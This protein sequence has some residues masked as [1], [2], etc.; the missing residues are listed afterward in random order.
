MTKLS[1]PVWLLL[2]AGCPAVD[3]DD[4]T[5]DDDDS[6]GLDLP[7]PPACEL[8]TLGDPLF[9]HTAQ[10]SALVG[11]L[12]GT[13]AAD[14]DGLGGTFTADD[15]EGTEVLLRGQA[16]AVDYVAL[17]GMS[18]LSAYASRGFNETFDDYEGA[19]FAANGD[20]LAQASTGRTVEIPGG[21]QASVPAQGG[22]SPQPAMTACWASVTS[23]PV[24][25]SRGDTELWLYSGQEATVDGMHVRLRRAL[26]YSDRIETD[27]CRREVTLDWDVVA[28]P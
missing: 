8:P 9:L 27:K 14:P 28:V 23:I 12:N 15:A 13:F 26:R 7:I 6:A 22:C 10:D 21:W 18:G 20:L 17:A 24:L 1:L 16:M 11:P 5:A 2:L 19:L 3:D 25:F 4:A